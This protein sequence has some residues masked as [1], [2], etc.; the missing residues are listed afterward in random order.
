LRFDGEVL[1][2]DE[3]S[4]AHSVGYSIDDVTAL[5]EALTEAKRLMTAG[6]PSAPAD[7]PRLQDCDGDIWSLDDNGSTYSLDRVRQGWTRERVEEEWGPVTEL[8]D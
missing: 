1:R 6:A 8:R 2:I 5:I 7:A 4:F 3:S